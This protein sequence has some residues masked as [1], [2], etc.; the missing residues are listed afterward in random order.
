MPLSQTI[1]TFSANGSPCRSINGDTHLR[2]DKGK[3]K[4]L[5]KVVPNF[6]RFA[7]RWKWG[8]GGGWGK[9]IMLSVSRSL[10]DLFI[11]EDVLRE[12]KTFLQGSQ[13]RGTN[14]PFSLVL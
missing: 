10:C 14:L 11:Y 5:G 12:R 8:G 7:D 2:K 3:G 13:N 9:S 4:A 6:I 1:K